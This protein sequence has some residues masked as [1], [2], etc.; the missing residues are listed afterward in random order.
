[1]VDKVMVEVTS[2]DCAVVG[3]LAALAKTV[4]AA[5][6]E[7]EALEYLGLVYVNRTKIADT[8]DKFRAVVENNW[9]EATINS[10]F[11]ENNE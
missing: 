1:M 2:A 6:N 10:A 9:P 4:L 11:G 8:V 5:K 7:E 3:L